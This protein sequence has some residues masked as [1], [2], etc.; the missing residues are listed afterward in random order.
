MHEKI[1]KVIS[2]LIV[3]FLA[4]TVFSTTISA[5][6]FNSETTLKEKIEGLNQKTNDLINQ[7]S[8]QQ[9]KD[10][11]KETNNIIASR[12]PTTS[13]IKTLQSYTALGA[14]DPTLR[15]YTNY[16]GQEK[17]TRLKLFF[18]TKIDVDGENGNDIG[19]R[20]TILPGIA[21]PLS[22]S[23]N[24]KLTI[25]QLTG[26]NQLD[27]NAFF[28]GY[29]ELY[30][31]GI[32]VKNL[33]G[34]RVRFG[35]QSP[36]G[37]K[38]PEKCD[39]IF[40]FIPNL[41]Y[42]RKKAGFH[43]AMIPDAT[44]TGKEKLNLLSGLAEMNG[45]TVV[46]EVY[47]KTLYNPAVETEISLS[48]GKSLG[49]RIFEFERQRSGDSQ[50]DMYIAI[51]EGANSTYAY[52]KEVP[53]LVTLSS[54]SGREGFIEFD[55]HGEA[56]D[57]IGVCDDFENPIN[58][59]YFSNMFTK[60]KIE[61][62]RDRLFLLKKGK[63]NVSIYTEG[64]GVS[65]NVHLEDEGNGS[66]DFSAL[67]EDAI[68]D[69]FMELDLSEGYF[70]LK[71][72]MYN[73]SLSLLGNGP[74]NGVLDA[75]LTLKKTE[76]K[77]FEIY[78]NGLK[79]GNAEILLAG[80]SFEIYN[81]DIKM[82]S[83][84]PSFNGEYSI[85][86]DHLEKTKEG[87]ID[88]SLSIVKEDKNVS[89]YCRF[90]IVHGVKITNLS[91]K[92]NNFEFKRTNIDE[93]GTI[94]H[95][96]NFSLN[97]TD[98]EWHDYGD[99]GYVL[100]KGDNSAFFSF[101]STYWDDDELIGT[102]SGAIKLKTTN[103]V[104]NIS[105]DT[106]DGNKTYYFDGS[107]VVGLY[108]FHFRMKDKI[109]VNIPK[110]SAT[111]TLNTADA[112][113][114]LILYIAEGTS[115][116]LDVDMDLDITD[117]FDITLQASI[118]L[119]ISGSASGTIGIAWN[120]S[121]KWLFDA[122]FGLEVSGSIS[123]TDFVLKYQENIIDVSMEELTI[124]GDLLEIGLY[125]EGEDLVFTAS[126]SFT[127]IV[128]SNINVDV[129]LPRSILPFSINASDISFIG[130]GEFIV[131]ITDGVITASANIGGDSELVINTLWVD[132]GIFV[133]GLEGLEVSGPTTVTLIADTSEEIPGGVTIDTADNITLDYL[134]LG[135]DFLMLYGLSGGGDS[136]FIF[137]SVNPH[138]NAMGFGLMPIITLAGAWHFDYVNVKEI[139]IPDISI[140]GSISLECW[141]DPTFLSWLYLSGAANEETTVTILG[142]DIILSP[143]GFNILLQQKKLLE[144]D[145]LST[146]G[147]KSLYLSA[148][149]HSWIKFRVPDVVELKFRGFINVRLDID[150]DND[151]KINAI[152]DL[153]DID[154]AVVVEDAIK[155]IGEAHGKLEFSGYI[156]NEGG[157]ITVSDIDID[158]SGEINAHIMIKPKDGDWIPLTDFSTNGAVV[159]LMDDKVDRPTTFKTPK[160]G[161][162]DVLFEAWYAPPIAVES[163]PGTQ[164]TYTFSFGEG[165]SYE[166]TTDKTEVTV[167]VSHLPDYALGE[168]H[169]SVVVSLEGYDDVDDDVTIVVMKGNYIDMSPSGMNG[170]V[171]N[172]D[173]VDENGKLHFS[174]KVKNKADEDHPYTLYWD[175]DVGTGGDDP[176]IYALWRMDE[177]VFEPQNGIL[178][179]GKETIVNVTA[180][181]PTDHADHIDLED[182]AYTFVNNTNYEEYTKGNEDSGYAQI[183]IYDGL[184]WLNPTDVMYLP[185]LDLGEEISSSFWI[186]NAGS[187]PLNWAVSDHPSNGTWSFSP[188]SGTIP[189]GSGG[190]VRF[191]IT[192]P[193]ENDVDL[194][195]EIKVINTA[196]SSD[197]DTVRVVTSTKS[198]G[199]PQGDVEITA[200]G[201]DISVKIGGYIDINV[202]N[203]VFEINGVSGMLNGHFFFESTDSYVYINFT[204]NDISSLS[205]DG[206]AEFSIENFKFAYGDG[207]NI[208]I[209]KVITGGFNCEQGKSGSFHIT[210]DDTFTDIDI[211][212]HLN[213]EFSN[214]TLVGN[215]DVDI[216]SSLDGSLWIE[217]DLNGDI[218]NVNIDGDLFGYNYMEVSI[219]DFNFTMNN[220]S[221]TA[222]EIYFNRAVDISWNETDLY[223]ESETIIQA[224]NIHFVLNGDLDIIITSGNIEIDGS[225]LFQFRMY[226]DHFRL[227][228][229]TTGLSLNGQIH[230]YFGDYY[231]YCTIFFTIVGEIWIE[232]YL[233]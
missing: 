206:S 60:A 104:F 98:V 185:T 163:E 115:G 53:E 92:F 214:F 220:F 1:K 159:L 74:D 153:K 6:W 84:L 64:E 87:S 83:Y 208:E 32:L 151:G 213:H 11:S 141:F 133:I 113:G 31:P 59:A 122:D 203:L 184:V 155:V 70:S 35:Y 147:H 114:E 130:E 175:T 224:S 112:S 177:W 101:D 49:K 215:L 99:W 178:N 90:D 54:K 201:N 209:S 233:D 132:I 179:A 171:F 14:N 116:M 61:W 16:N 210:V 138:H 26:F 149:A 86:M 127:N 52:V 145:L 230:V 81:L 160:G 231:G 232:V 57:E 182:C 12:R 156:S 152:F 157:V 140:S 168:Y 183:I 121:G 25:R 38:T 226:D 66:L 162:E 40:K 108:D 228:I 111:F 5:K 77:P 15:F 107:G 47:S 195:G 146:E 110:I 8:E 82:I 126:G 68:I 227:Y 161:V 75:S 144:G 88:S 67:S 207:I 137:F 48:R 190:S 96:Y 62:N 200:D 186:R 142:I 51:T 22:L 106:V 188:S 191:T 56:V 129:N 139:G 7:L 125:T 4:T 169:A 143:G 79:E 37:E 30:F 176:D 93:T 123:V 134:Y 229:F 199:Q 165:T 21:R 19:V 198:S 9:S 29:A 95:W 180:Y 181:P 158:L 174:F 187:Q 204:K 76:D 55:A 109:E 192:A 44:T 164:Y 117:L 72:S 20:Y 97:I 24:F 222:D 27:E 216:S 50:V 18:E 196:D 119:D 73:I 23:I 154:G 173:E 45:D 36:E 102:I 217:W 3:F 212:L 46:S 100:I 202:D 41:I 2:I 17:E 189:P 94:T 170:V 105:W 218:K 28:E 136:G 135:P 69:V 78:F 225:L 128:I 211:N 63:A 65:F 103:D 194:S 39:V 71:H 33:S 131:E 10:N 172:Y 34:D 89:G 197:Y 80:K 91:L 42:P 221:F 223:L 166:I 148:D 13:L 43:F 120:E 124:S 193:A 150:V 205:V 167:P 219:T 58:K 85:T 118:D